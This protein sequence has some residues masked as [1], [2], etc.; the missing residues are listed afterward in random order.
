MCS[1]HYQDIGSSTPPGILALLPHHT[2]SQSCADAF[3]S[4][5]Q[6]NSGQTRPHARHSASIQIP[7]PLTQTKTAEYHK[8]WDI[9]D[10]ELQPFL[11]E[12]MFMT[13]VKRLLCQQID[14]GHWGDSKIGWDMEQLAYLFITL[15]T[16]A[17]AECHYGVATAWCH[18]TQSKVNIHIA[19]KELED[20]NLSKG[21][22]AVLVQ[23]FSNA[24]LWILP[25][26][27][28]SAKCL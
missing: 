13:V 20:H 4:L 15:L 11:E 8:W 23:V 21:L 25:D 2:I 26:Q 9:G 22:L 6:L 10:T 24:S 28:L 7:T 1:A 17:V 14:E 18:P 16:Q 3:L 19:F 5:F 27:P 12:Y